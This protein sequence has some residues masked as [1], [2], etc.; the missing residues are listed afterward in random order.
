MKLDLNIA[1]KSTWLS[2]NAPIMI[3]GPCSVESEEQ[4][5]QTAKEIAK[6]RKVSILR[7]GIWKPRTR[8]NSFEGVGEEG[9]MWLKNAGL[10]VGL[11]VATEVA[12]A[13]HVEACLKKGIDVLWVGAR[14]TVNPFS[15]QE[16]AEALKGVDI[17]VF[18]KNP[19]IPDINLWIGA[20]ERL[21]AVGINKLAAIHRGFASCDKSSYRNTP[22]WKIPIE[23]KL[24]CP[25]LPMLCDPSHITGDKDLISYV[26]QKALDL[27]MEGLMIESHINPLVARSDA[28]QQVTPIELDTLL[29]DLIIREKH[30]KSEEFINKLEQLRS[31]ID[32]LDEELINKF[33]SRMEII[34]KI[35]AYKGENNVTILQLERWE[36]ILSNRTFLAS[37][38]GLSDDFIKK[39]LELVHQESIRLQTQV[40]NHK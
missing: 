19:I 39:M 21:N 30:S 9:L 22:M 7:G 24:M 10:E 13:E 40:M 34:E 35:G 1:D 20:L 11:P 26:A 14:T 15:V 36:K 4:M 5:M 6:T 23:L 27:D 8:P 3:S 31:V 37:K 12:N 2:K 25:E 16:I 28:K 33:A 18:V 32:D 29:S 17:P 38:V